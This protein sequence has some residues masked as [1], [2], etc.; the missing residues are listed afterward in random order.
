MLGRL[1]FLVGGGAG[2]PT[3]K[4]SGRVDVE[5][6]NFWNHPLPLSVSFLDPKRTGMGEDGTCH[7]KVKG[8]RSDTPPAFTTIKHALCRKRHQPTENTQTHL[9]DQKF[10]HKNKWVQVLL[11]VCGK[12]PDFSAVSARFVE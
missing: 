9:F 2:D 4:H 10:Q 8:Q 7:Q 11:C 5:H 12:T 6:C 3:V 1:N